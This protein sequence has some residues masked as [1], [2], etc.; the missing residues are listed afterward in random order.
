MRISEC[1]ALIA[2][3]SAHSET[4]TPAS[5]KRSVR[6]LSLITHPQG[7]HGA[8]QF[9]KR[10]VERFDIQRRQTGQQE[11]AQVLQTRPDLR[12][13]DFEQHRQRSVQTYDTEHVEIAQLVTLRRF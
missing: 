1:P 8:W 3:L 4:I 10:I 9:A 11:A 7:R 12:N 13:A 2:G 6:M 5:F